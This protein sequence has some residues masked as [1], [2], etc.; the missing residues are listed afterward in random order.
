M[1][2]LSAAFLAEIDK[3][4]RKPIQLAKFYLPGEIVYLS[5]KV[6]GIADG[7]DYEYEPWVE[8][9]GSLND[10]S[11]I[12][13]LYEGNSLE[14]RACTI[15]IIVSPQSRTFVKKLFQTGIEN[16]TVE[17][18]QWF[19]GVG[20]DPI[21]IDVF[22]C[23]DPIQNSEASML[24]TI[25]LVS[26]LMKSN[27]YLWPEAAGKEKQP[28][29]IG[30]A[31]GMDLK[32][33]QTSVKTALAQDITFNQTG[34]IFIGNGVGFPA[35]G[36]VS[37]DSEDLAYS[38]I[39]ASAIVITA[40]GQ[41]GTTARPHYRGGLMV[42]Y[43]AI[44]D[45]VICSGPV[46]SVDNLLGNGVAYQNAVTFFTGQN[47]VIA[48]FVGRPPWL[49]VSPG[50]GGDD[51][52]PDPVTSTE[53]GASYQ[54][55]LSIAGPISSPSAI[56]AAAGNAVMSMS[57][58]VQGGPGSFTKY[59]LSITYNNLGINNYTKFHGSASA[60]SG[61]Q[62]KGD[63]G[64]FGNLQATT[65]GSIDS[66]YG[67]NDSAYGNIVSTSVR[68]KF[69]NLGNT[70]T[71]AHIKLRI[72]LVLSG[73]SSTTLQ[74]WDVNALTSVYPG[75]TAPWNNSTFTYP[76]SIGNFTILQGA[77]VRIEAE[78]VSAK[79]QA[80][81]STYSERLRT[82]F[83][84]V[85]W[86][87]NYFIPAGTVPEPYQEL[88]SHFN[89]DLSSLGAITNVTAKVYFSAAL[90]NAEALLKI[91]K[92]S[93]SNIAD[94]TTL[95]SANI[96][97]NISATEY[98]YSLGSMSWA[99]LQA[100]RIGVFHQITGPDTEGTTRQITTS[101]SYVKWVITYQP[102]AIETP[103]EERVVYAD[104][105][106]CDVTSLLGADP[107][108]PQVIEFLLDTYSES[109]Q[110]IDAADFSAAHTAYSNASYF[111]NGVLD[112]GIQLHEALKQVLFEGS[113]RFLFNQGKIKLITYFDEQELTV[114]Y[115]ISTDD[116]QL[117]S[118]KTVNQPT[119]SVRNDITISYD[120]DYLLD[121]FNGQTNVVDSTSLAKFYRKDYRAELVLVDSQTVA[122][123]F[124]N[125]LLNLLSVPK[126]IYSF[127][128]FFKAFQLEKG[129][130]VSLQT[131]LDN[132]FWYEGSI[133]SIQRVFGQGKTGQINLFKLS[134]ANPKSYARL[135]L[136]DTLA[137]NDNSIELLKGVVLP[138][139]VV[140]LND[141]DISVEKEYSLYERLYVTDILYLDTCT[142]NGFGG[143]KFGVLPYGD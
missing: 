28:V 122:T 58:T 13:N 120:K 12:N 17:L 59:G 63:S 79:T 18:F 64:I 141:S 52:I 38:S 97:S 95:F 74:E 60:N 71:A 136:L 85:E 142:D 47:P 124:A 138:T 133:L 83:N 113:C 6:V 36:V 84:G 104:T 5:D 88:V 56:N 143:C 55:T 123:M 78:C 15:T 39:S 139:E 48:R 130:R 100:L 22:V 82:L 4:N 40:R 7:L 101:F 19:D 108:P 128:M 57:S 92:R 140:A 21:L 65:I 51:I 107:T 20:E 77:K 109:G 3:K 14:I 37:I 80:E 49:K 81:Y 91:V 53:Y 30:K 68:V 114:D 42:P 29:V 117:R 115:S 31:T 75:V 32:D 54:E 67:R 90:T 112:A 137:L 111:L 132:R 61:G 94:N 1:L 96:T 2:T 46:Q 121:V 24:L 89:R 103:D 11:F 10:N 44:Y 33:L 43:G 119:E 116:I 135:D 129:D 86:I 25:D 105:L 34:S 110:Y 35:S 41:N 9:W 93:T 134:V 126:A 69:N 72:I 98:T 62:L 27:P 50:A 118:R 70:V 26:P 87:V 8:S 106:T 16:T 45:Y 76:V 131:F 73:G 99:S 23:Q 127:N 125:R 102:G 66:D